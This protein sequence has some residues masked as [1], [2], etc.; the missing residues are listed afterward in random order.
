M[1]AIL[2]LQDEW[3]DI[4]GDGVYALQHK[5]CQALFTYEGGVVGYSD[6]LVM[7]GYDGNHVNGYF[8]KDAL[9]WIEGDEA[10]AVHSS[11]DIKGFPFVPKTFY[12]DVVSKVVNGKKE[13]FMKDASQL[14]EALAYYKKSG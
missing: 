7:R 10:K 4:S 14:E 11:L 1:K 8:W 12:I 3:V 2:G 9:D 13:Y 5:E 6:A